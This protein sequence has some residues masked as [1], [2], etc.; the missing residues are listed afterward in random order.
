M[1][2]TIAYCLRFDNFPWIKI[3]TNFKLYRNTRIEQHTFDLG[4]EALMP[5]QHSPNHLG[6]TLC[7]NTSHGWKKYI[8]DTCVCRN[9]S[10]N[11]IY[12]MWYGWKKVALSKNLFHFQNQ[13]YFALPMIVKTYL[14][15]REKIKAGG[16]PALFSKGKVQDFS[17][18]YS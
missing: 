3:T 5:F 1:K 13:L 10:G 16:V 2:A 4:I 15:V 12:G 14:K 6:A 17:T 8:K 18:A 11:R 7:G 9:S